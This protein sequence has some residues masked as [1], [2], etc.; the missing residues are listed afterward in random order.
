MSDCP[1]VAL[2]L[3]LGTAL[4]HLG[5]A[6]EG[7]RVI[8]ADLAATAEEHAITTI[9]FLRDTADGR[10]PSPA[11]LLRSRG[12]IEALL[13]QL[14]DRADA[15]EATLSELNIALLPNADATDPLERR[16]L[17]AFKD[18]YRSAAPAPAADLAAPS[19]VSAPPHEA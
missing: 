16:A 11:A 2:R 7:L 3:E 9:S 8:A 6:A 13:Q 19:T 18:R 12:Q 15:E 4:S 10:A 5:D 17:D 1:P 14:L